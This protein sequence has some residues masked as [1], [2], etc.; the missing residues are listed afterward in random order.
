MYYVRNTLL[1][2]CWL[3]H[4][5]S[6]RKELQRLSDYR[7][8]YNSRCHSDVV[9]SLK[10]LHIPGTPLC[11]EEEDPL[12][13]DEK[14]NCVSVN[15]SSTVASPTDNS[16]LLNNRGR[17]AYVFRMCFIVTVFFSVFTIIATAIVFGSKGK[18]F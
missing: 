8:F 15:D 9:W 7:N 12:E 16:S 11:Y 10:T 3:F 2:V 13:I 5:Q 14:F 17:K 4:L 18:L 1:L 6:E